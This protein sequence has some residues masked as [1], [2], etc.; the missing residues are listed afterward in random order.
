MLP[1][2]VSIPGF[3]FLSFCVLLISDLSSRSS[4]V[5]AFSSES[6]H[7]LFFSSNQLL[8]FFSV[9]ASWTLPEVAFPH[10]ANLSPLLGR[11]PPSQGCSPPLKVILPPSKSFPPPSWDQFFRK[12]A[13]PPCSTIFSPSFPLFFCSQFSFSLNFSS[14]MSH[15]HWHSHSRS[16]K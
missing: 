12:S 11:F 10:S 7:S 9:L 5:P 6:P 13:L 4:P 8:S 15:Q 16:S 14:S 3:F 1:T 2:N